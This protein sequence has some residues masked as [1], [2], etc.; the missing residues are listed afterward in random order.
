M[1]IKF[2]VAGL[3]VETTPNSEKDADTN[4]MQL[5]VI[6]G[7]RRLK[8]KTLPRRVCKDKHDA[9]QIAHLQSRSRSGQTVEHAH[10]PQ[11]VTLGGENRRGRIDHFLSS[12]ALVPQAILN[13]LESGAAFSV[14]SE[15]GLE[16]VPMLKKTN[17]RAVRLRDEPEPRD[18]RS[19]GCGSVRGR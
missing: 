8:R 7:T 19:K 12:N 11:A 18:H 4:A 17:E 15:N 1:C 13:L 14:M 16:K 10:R 6:E 2:R 9:R 3:V 5:E